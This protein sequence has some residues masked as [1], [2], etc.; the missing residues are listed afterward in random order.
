MKRCI[1]LR[2]LGRICCLF[3]CGAVFFCGK[4]VCAQSAASKV[5]ERASSSSA[6]GYS[7]SVSTSSKAATVY[8]PLGGP[9]TLSLRAEYFRV[10]SV[11]KITEKVWD[12]KAD[13]KFRSVPLTVSYMY[14]LPS[15]NDR[16]VPVVGAGVSAHFFKETEKIR[17]GGTAFIST[18]FGI[19]NTAA[20]DFMDRYGLKYGAELSLGV[21]T[22]L[23]RQIFILTEARYR[24]VN[25]S[26]SML[27]NNFGS[28]AVNV[29]DFSVDVGFAF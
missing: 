7:I 14:S 29:V 10:A 15:P 18:P 16:I 20:S 23:T 26:A 4:R 8:L 5:L 27:R 13:W 9:H 17:D 11:P 22:Q 3:L 1:L 19:V 28:E 25:C 2:T 21:R 6:D 12:V 24:Y